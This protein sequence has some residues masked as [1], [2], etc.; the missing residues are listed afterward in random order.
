[1]IKTAIKNTKQLEKYHDQNA[2]KEQNPSSKIY[3]IIEFLDEY[4]PLYFVD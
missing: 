2:Y 3:K 1:M 4:I